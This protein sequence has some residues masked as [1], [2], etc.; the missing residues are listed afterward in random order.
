MIYYHSALRL[1][2]RLLYAIAQVGVSLAQTMIDRDHS[3]A[4]V[5]GQR[6]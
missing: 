3:K 1:V 4:I 2:N 5:P 6:G